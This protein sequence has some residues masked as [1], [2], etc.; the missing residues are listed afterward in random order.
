MTVSLFASISRLFKCKPQWPGALGKLSENPAAM[1]EV[2]VL[3]RMVL[4]DGVVHP[5]QLT[6]FERICERQFGISPRDMPELHALLES[7]KARSCDAQAF[8]LLGQLDTEARKALLDDMKRIACAK[9]GLNVG[10]DRL[11]RRTASLLGLEPGPK[12][13]GEKG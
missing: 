13:A 7:P 2:L 8:T 10:E 6:A 4:A 5:S 3:F 1:A 12:P 9:D 11:L